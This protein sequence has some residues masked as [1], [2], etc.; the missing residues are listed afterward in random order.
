MSRYQ[1]LEERD[2]D[3]HG[4]GNKGYCVGPFFERREGGEVGSCDESLQTQTDMS[5]ITSRRIPWNFSCWWKPF[6]NRS[7]HG[8][9]IEAPGRLV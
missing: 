3:W 1:T 9:M 5:N 6:G 4:M 8:Y 7:G 2:V